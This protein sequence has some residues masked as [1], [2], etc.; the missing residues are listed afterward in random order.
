M[1]AVP[2]PVRISV[3]EYLATSYRPDCDYVDGVVEER[4]LGEFDH[5]FLQGLLFRLFYDNREKWAVRVS[6]EQRI[7]L[8]PRIVIRSSCVLPPSEKRRSAERRLS[9]IALC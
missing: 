7:Q 4:S 8:S 9:S 3:G 5:S 6:P 2:I 1:N